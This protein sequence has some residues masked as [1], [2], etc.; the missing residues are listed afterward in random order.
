[1]TIRDWK[2][3]D[4]EVIALL[5]KQNFNDP[6]S[7]E[8][9]DECF[10]VPNFSGFVC[11]ENDVICGY[12]CVA[13]ACDEADVLDLCVDTVFR[14][15]GY[16]AML[17]ESAI[18]F[19]RSKLVTNVFL[20]V[21]VSNAAAIGLYEKLGFEKVGIRKKYYENTEDAYVYGLKLGD[22]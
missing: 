12:V 10:S 16:G 18:S 9:F 1:M 5:E 15:K 11:E 17:M 2:K 21:R 19:L 13:Y 22:K 7:K 3:S 8:M 4:N 20:E 14:R 6:W